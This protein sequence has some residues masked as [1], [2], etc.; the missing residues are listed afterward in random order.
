MTVNFAF[1]QLLKNEVIFVCF[2]GESALV[3]GG[4]GP[5]HQRVEGCS[6]QQGR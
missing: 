1:L 5:D 4:L 3:S 2:S 6:V